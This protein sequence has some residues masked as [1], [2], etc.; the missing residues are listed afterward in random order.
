[1]QKQTFRSTETASTA[2]IWFLFYMK[3]F[4]VCFA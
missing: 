2:H 4:Y 1:M 3:Y